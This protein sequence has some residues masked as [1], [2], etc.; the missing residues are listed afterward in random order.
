MSIHGCSLNNNLDAVE[1]FVNLHRDRLHW[2]RPTGGS[3]AFIQVVDPYSGAPVDDAAFCQRLVQ[4][5]GLLLPRLSLE[6]SLVLSMLV[7]FVVS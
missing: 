3:A 6:M 4:E 5:T 1:S 7:T 2:V